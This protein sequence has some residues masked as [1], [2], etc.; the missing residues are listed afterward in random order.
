MTT[1]PTTLGWRCIGTHPE[2]DL[3]AVEIPTGVLLRFTY[4]NEIP[5]VRQI[6][7]YTMCFVP[8]L[9]IVTETDRD[10]DRHARLEVME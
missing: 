10:G 5:E 6:W 8:G 7:D 3:W 2:G 4:I 9:C 1:K